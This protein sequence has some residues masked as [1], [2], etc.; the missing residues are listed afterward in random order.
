LKNLQ[1][2]GIF[3]FKHE[4]SGGLDDPIRRDCQ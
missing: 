1:S 4:P 2:L 3:S